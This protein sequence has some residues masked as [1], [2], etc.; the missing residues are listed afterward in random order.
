LNLD[1]LGRGE[2]H[3]FSGFS[4]NLGTVDWARQTESGLALP[5]NSNSFEVLPAKLKTREEFGI[6]FN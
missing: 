2:F 3:F 5:S 6:S 4:A 1:S